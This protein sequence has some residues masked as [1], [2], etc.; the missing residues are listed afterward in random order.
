MPGNLSTR[1]S[2]Y[3]QVMRIVLPDQSIRKVDHRPC[4]VDEVLLSLGINPLEVIVSRNG[5]LLPEG[6]KVGT[7][8][9]IRVIRIAH[10]G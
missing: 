10:G 5:I 7:E 4:S 2:Q 3:Y 6:T 8:D 1:L 9:E